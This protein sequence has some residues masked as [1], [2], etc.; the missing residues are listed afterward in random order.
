MYNNPSVLKKT[1]QGSNIIRLLFKKIKEKPDKFIKFPIS[2]SNSLGL[3]GLQFEMNMDA[4]YMQFTDVHIDGMQNGEY[5]KIVT[6]SSIFVIAY[7]INGNPL[8]ENG[9]NIVLSINNDQKESAIVTIQNIIGSDFQGNQV[10][11]DI[12][13][14]NVKV[15]PVPEAFNISTST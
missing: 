9:M 12:S 13:N 8:S 14:Y 4:N 3:S 5:H 10:S 15:M 1:K 11:M 6:D 2:I 7:S